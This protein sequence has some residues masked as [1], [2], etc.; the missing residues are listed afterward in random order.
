MFSIAKTYTVR[1]IFY[2]SEAAIHAPG[3]PSANTRQALLVG[4]GSLRHEQ[5]AKQT[6]KY[7]LADISEANQNVVL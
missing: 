2:V 7:I 4:G 1:D 5:E 6:Y 3:S